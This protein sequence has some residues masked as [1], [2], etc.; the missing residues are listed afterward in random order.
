MEGRETT[1]WILISE[2]T[3]YRIEE[4]EKCHKQHIL[5]KSEKSGKYCS[6]CGRKIFDSARQTESKL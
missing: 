1:R 5:H 3:D 4:C 2:G 6:E